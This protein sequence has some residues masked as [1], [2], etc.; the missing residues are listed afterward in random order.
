MASTRFFEEGALLM[1]RLFRRLT[2]MVSSLLCFFLINFCG[3]PVDAKPQEAFLPAPP[4]L[5]VEGAPRIPM[6]LVDAAGSYHTFRAASFEDWHPEKR[7]MLI[8]TTFSDTPQLHLV[9]APGGARQQLTFFA[10]GVI[11]AQFEPG[12]GD[13]IVFMKDTNGNES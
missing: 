4:N 6:T 8:T 5:V 11:S 2:F 9:S 3:T 13:S 1:S 10:D 12:D 7:Q